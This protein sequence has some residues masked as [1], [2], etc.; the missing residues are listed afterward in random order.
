MLLVATKYQDIAGAKSAAYRHASANGT[1]PAHARQIMYA[2][3]PDILRLTRRDQ[4]D[5]HYFTQPL[6][7]DF[8]AEYPD[9]TAEWDV[10]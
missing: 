4:L 8:M 1:L 5:D 9:Q 6:L 2:A 3:R 7:P 10:V